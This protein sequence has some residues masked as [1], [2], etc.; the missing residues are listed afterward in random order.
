M[1]W[2]LAQSEHSS[3]GPFYNLCDTVTHMFSQGDMLA[4]P[5]FLVEH[6]KTLS[7]VWAVVFLIVGLLCLLNGYR[8]YRI[9]T[10]TVAFLFGLF[11]GYWLGDKIGAPEIV[12]GCLGLLFAV[13]AF[14]LMK[15]AV[16]VFGGLAGAFIGANLWSG[17]AG[18]LNTAGGLE[19][20]HEAFWV[21]ALMGLL[22]CGMLAFILFKLS[23]VL[24]TSVSGSTVMVLGGLALLLSFEPWQNSISTHLAAHQLV[25]PLLVIVPATIGLI[26]Q[27]A[28]SGEED[29][30]P[31]TPSS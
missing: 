22:I 18:A 31:D 16:A 21:G 29:I 9:A 4:Q 1:L 13:T 5:Q 11:M 8:F 17:I 3:R 19:I 2:S 26:F 12:G 15:Y 23:V 27:E 30:S 10:I 25:I 24:F 20:P 14:P 7:V 6:L 28:W